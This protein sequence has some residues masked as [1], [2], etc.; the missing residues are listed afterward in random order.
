MLYY[1]MRYCRCHATILSRRRHYAVLFAD[2]EI[3]RT[4]RR[5]MIC[6]FR[7]HTDAAAMPPRRCQRMSLLR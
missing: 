6:Y 2:A 1:A 4:L 5:L 7:Y 3:L